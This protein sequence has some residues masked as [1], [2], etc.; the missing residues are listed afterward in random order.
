MFVCTCMYVCITA[1]VNVCTHVLLHIQ[2]E[3]D[4]F[5]NCFSP[6]A[7]VTRGQTQA[8]RIVWPVLYPRRHLAILSPLV[9]V[10]GFVVIICELGAYLGVK[11]SEKAPI[12][13]VSSPHSVGGRRKLTGSQFTLREQRT[14]AHCWPGSNLLNLLDRPTAPLPLRSAPA[15]LDCTFQTP[16]PGN[17]VSMLDNHSNNHASP[18]CCRKSHA[19]TYIYTSYWLCTHGDSSVIQ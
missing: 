12:S 11:L 9:S 18:I 16:Q 14:P 2:K 8:T 15:H 6:P 5:R 7:V 1:C 17:H 3:E 13:K 19:R 4:T 10:T